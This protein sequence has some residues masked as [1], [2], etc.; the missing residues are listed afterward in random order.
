MS[1]IACLNNSSNP[2]MPPQASTTARPFMHTPLTVC[3]YCYHPH[4]Q[5]N[6]KAAHW[7]LTPITTV[8]FV[9][10][11][12]Y[13]SALFNHFNHALW[14]VVR[15]KASEATPTVAEVSEATCK[16]LLCLIE[17][18][19]Q[20]GQNFLDINISNLSFRIICVAN[21][22]TRVCLPAVLLKLL[23]VIVEK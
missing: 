2:C 11:T 8:T 5:A 10:Y 6:T 17:F 21:S 16:H 1:Y 23:V 12:I 3:A 15:W 20:D 14:V 22:L 19:V 13:L 9:F 4:K 18:S 7:L